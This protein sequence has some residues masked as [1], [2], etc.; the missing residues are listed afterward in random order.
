[1][2]AVPLASKAMIELLR[3]VDV[4]RGRTLGVK[5][6]EAFESMASFSQGD[7]L[8]DQLDDIQCISD[9][10]QNLGWDFF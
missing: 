9:F 4:K 3:L 6:A 2:I 1:M 7:A 5:R 8:A 10:F